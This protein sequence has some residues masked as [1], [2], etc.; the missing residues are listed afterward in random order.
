M[1]PPVTRSVV[2]SPTLFPFARGVGLMGEAGPEAILPLK[3]GSD[4]KLGVSAGGGGG[5]SI[6]VNNSAGARVQAR[7]AGLDG[8]GRRLIEIAVS[9]AEARVAGNMAQGS[10]R[11]FGV[12]P[13]TKKS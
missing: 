13:G 4:G 6:V 12:T 8:A 7:D 3:R 2:S 11:R 9:E 10:Y 1:P 5:V